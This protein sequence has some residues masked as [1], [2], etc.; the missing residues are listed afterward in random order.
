MAHDGAGSVLIAKVDHLGPDVLA[1]VDQ[2]IDV[3][4]P[5]EF[6]QDRVP[7]SVNLPV[8]T[9]AE[10][11]RVGTIYVQEDKFR[12]R[13]IG[14]ALIGR[15]IAAHLEGE[16]ADKGGGWRALVYCWRGGQRS[17]AMATVLSQVG[18]RVSVLQGG[19]RTYRQAVV[20]ALYDGQPVANLVLLGGRTGVGKTELLARL[21]ARGV[22]TLDLEALADHRG[23]LLGAMP[24]RP[25]PSQK[26]WESRLAGALAELDP[27]RPVLV[28]AESSKVG[29]RA[30]PP[31]LWR[32]MTDAPLIELVAPMQAR[33]RNLVETYEGLA[34]DHGAF[35]AALDRLPRHIGRAEVDSWRGLLEAGERLALAESLVERHYDPAYARAARSRA[36]PVLGRLDLPDLSEASRD[37]AAEQVIAQLEARF[38]RAC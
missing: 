12:A 19:Y 14:A 34:D 8:L 4:S 33:A 17:G 28:E 18:W 24:G 7:G 32:A 3:R 31:V 13:R 38:G 21:R 6:A 27:G 23:S 10:R 30:I 29:E 37:R 26:L 35:A 22:Q 9:D 25:Q 2:V 15:N 20:K 36:G 5:G 11:A 16:L 1:G